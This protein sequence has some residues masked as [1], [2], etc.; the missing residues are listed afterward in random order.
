MNPP[1]ADKP[2]ADRIGITMKHQLPIFAKGFPN[3]RQAQQN[4]RSLATPSRHKHPSS[5]IQRTLINPRPLSSQNVMHLQ[6]TIGNSAV[7]QLL[8]VRLHSEVAP[9]L[10]GHP[11]QPKLNIGPA[12]D[13]YEREADRVAR[14]VTKEI[15]TSAYQ[16]IQREKEREEEETLQMKPEASTV[17]R[18]DQD[19]EEE[20]MMK[21]TLK[22]QPAKSGVAAP[23]DVEAAIQQSRGSGQAL[24]INVRRPMEQKLGA[25]FSGVRV[26]TD[27][28]SD[29]LNRSLSARA[30]TTGRDI[31]FKQE[32][33]DPNSSAGQSLLVHELTHVVQQNGGDLLAPTSSSQQV[34]RKRLTTENVL[35]KKNGKGVKKKVSRPARSSNRRKRQRKQR[36]KQQ[37]NLQATCNRI[38]KYCT[39]I[40]SALWEICRHS[41]SVIEE[42]SGGRAL[43]E[44]EAVADEARSEIHRR[45]I[46]LFRAAK[47]IEME[48]ERNIQDRLNDL[49]DIEQALRNNLPQQ[50]NQHAKRVAF[51]AV[52]AEMP[53]HAKEIMA[54]A[55]LVYQEL[56]RQEQPEDIEDWRSARI[57]ERDT[58]HTAVDVADVLNNFFGTGTGVAG[59]IENIGGVVGAGG[60]AVVGGIGGAFGILFGAIGTAF[61]IYAYARGAIKRKA[62]KKISPAISNQDLAEITE[63]SKE[64]KWKKRFRG[65]FVAGLGVLAITAGILGLIAINV[66][67][68]GIPAVMIGLAAAIMGLSLVAMKWYHAKGKRELERRDFAQTMVD[69]IRND[70]D[71]ADEFSQK[72]RD[73]G[74][75][76]SEVDTAEEQRLVYNLAQRVGD[77]VKSKRKET[78]EEIINFMLYGSPSEQFDAELIVRTLGRDPDKIRQRVAQGDY[79]TA[80]SRLMAKMASW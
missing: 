50:L 73:L 13:Q 34:S 16:P 43:V 12:N 45:F 22:R 23:S 52:E 72:I 62:L 10:D 28:K 41:V 63:Y 14:Q 26:H 18:Q 33:Y 70:G 79:N 11:I 30:F 5:V 53:D 6:R 21:P 7:R 57:R 3:K 55:D 49:R 19:E 47:I 1:E 77:L 61:G 35:Q 40:D 78:A 54:Q 20:S 71:R 46:D 64:Q 67:T 27:A 56:G 36:R 48:Q 8:T 2:L 59:G 29:R 17:Q 68:L 80:V 44:A 9:T 65:G 24:P 66:T 58:A 60:G 75:D 38:E 31:F 37:R 74:L 76:P 15:S 25:D 39:T 42:G 4:R 69:E 51:I 32:A